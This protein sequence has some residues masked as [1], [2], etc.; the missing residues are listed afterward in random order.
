MQADRWEPVEQQVGY[1]VKRVQQAVRAA[2][3]GA[4]AAHG[5]GMAQYAALAAL[6]QEPGLSNA[7]LARRS[8]VT[9]QSMHAIV[10]ALQERGLVERVPHPAHGR[11]LQARLTAEGEA[12]AGRCHEAAAGVHDRMLAGMDEAERAWLRDALRRC[13][14]S[15]EEAALHG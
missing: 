1:L 3:D 13:A 10:A 11:V 5:V 8:F 6:Q 14:A 2:L 9:A 7:E 15:L 12:M 4:L